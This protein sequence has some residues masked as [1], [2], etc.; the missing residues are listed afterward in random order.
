ME[1][2]NPG[3]WNDGVTPLPPSFQKI[4][5]DWKRLDVNF[6]TGFL[7]LVIPAILFDLWGAVTTGVI[8]EHKRGHSGGY[9]FGQEPGGFLTELAVDVVFLAFSLYALIFVRRKARDIAARRRSLEDHSERV[10]GSS[11][12]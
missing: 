10:S 4:G 11:S 3:V 8:A 7:L 9:S 6:L 2:R 12:D 1:K 5:K